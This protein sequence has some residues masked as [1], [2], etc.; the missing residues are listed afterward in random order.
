M[1]ASLATPAGQA[2][3]ADVPNFASG[4]AKVLIAAID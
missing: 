3:G 4:G 2:P 1:Q